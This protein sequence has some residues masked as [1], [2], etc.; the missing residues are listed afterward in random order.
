MRSTEDTLIRTAGLGY[1]PHV[2]TIFEPYVAEVDRHI[3]TSS[4]THDI[5]YAQ[6]FLD[7]AHMSS[8]GVHPNDAGYKVIAAHLR[9]LDY[10]PLSSA[11]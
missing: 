6:L 7:K 11:S 3:A 2:A 8:D 5:P 9:E 10:E 4:A 1:T